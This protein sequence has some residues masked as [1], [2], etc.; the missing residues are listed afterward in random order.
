MPSL[1]RSTNVSLFS[2]LDYF[3]LTLQVI[4]LG[5]GVIFIYGTG[6][7]IGGDFASKWYKQLL[8]IGL[9]IMVYVASASVD[10]RLLGKVSAFFY[11]AVLLL[12][13]SLFFI[14]ATINGS[15][16]WIVL[17]GLGLLQPS[18]LA[19]P[20]TLLFASWVAS[21]PAVRNNNFPAA[22]PILAVVMLPVFLVCLQP[23]LGTA[24]VFMPFS[25]ALL[26]L[27]GL[28]WRWFFLGLALLLLALPPAFRL[29]APH[30]KERIKVFLEAPSEALLL[31][32]SPFISEKLEQKLSARK[33][34]FFA[35]KGGGLRDSW[36]AEQSLLAVGSGGLYGKG[37][38][39]GTHHVL[40]YLPKTVAPTDFIFS[41][42]AEESGFIGSM[43]LLILFCCLILCYCRTA[44]LARNSFGANLALGAAV[45]LA[46]HIIINIGMTVQALPII[47]IPLPFVSYGGSFMV[48]IMLLSGLVQN[49]HL[50]RRMPQH[51]D[52]KQ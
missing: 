36:N 13:C 12:L 14:G 26:L 16:S 42:I 33:E 1:Q 32:G 11:V 45:I 4:L 6:I 27:S 31:A 21:L 20:V 41:V 2:R 52:D 10:Y 19:K 34:A 7:E 39:K 29:M 22:I 46:T 40:G 25:V 24:L 47:G 38:L 43:V 15:R 44:L 3:A 17:P 8:W 30:Q 23:D 35:V 9:G 5:V 50:R 37:Y 51:E 49:V 18:E 48:C 28:R